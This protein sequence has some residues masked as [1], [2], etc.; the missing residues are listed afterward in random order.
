MTRRIPPYSPE[1]NPHEIVWNILKYQ[2]IPDFRPDSLEDLNSP[3]VKTLN[4]L[5]SDPERPRFAIRASVLP[6]PA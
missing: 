5:K 2:E 6:L 3:V 1:L 4:M